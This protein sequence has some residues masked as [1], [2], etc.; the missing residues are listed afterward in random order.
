MYRNKVKEERSIRP[1]TSV[2]TIE[3]FETVNFPASTEIHMHNACTCSDGHSDL[4][5]LWSVFCM[6]SLGECTIK[7]IPCRDIKWKVM[8]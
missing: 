3:R 6:D 2:R 7:R 5:K 4:F 8:I 1:S